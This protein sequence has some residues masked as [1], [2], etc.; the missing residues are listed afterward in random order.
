MRFISRSVLVGWQTPALTQAWVMS[1]IHYT[2]IKSLPAT[3]RPSVTAP[4]WSTHSSGPHL[5]F[6]LPRRCLPGNPGGGGRGGGRRARPHGPESGTW[7]V[8]TQWPGSRPVTLIRTELLLLEL[9]RGQNTMWEKGKALLENCYRLQP[10][11]LYVRVCWW[12]HANS[13]ESLEK[14]NK[15]LFLVLKCS[16]SSTLS[17]TQT[18]HSHTHI[19]T[20]S[21]WTCMN[22][23]RKLEHKEKRGRHWSSDPS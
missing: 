18:I 13:K 15:C 5:C 17:S 14:L 20:N 11:M 12:R 8:K 4:L 2:M 19:K 22:C 10:N 3:P 9:Q 21:T 7:W 16:N 23:R 6:W 1:S